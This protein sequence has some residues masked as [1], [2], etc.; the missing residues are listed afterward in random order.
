MTHYL[1]MARFRSSIH[2][3]NRVKHVVDKSAS[4]TG[5]TTIGESLI[6]TVDAPVLAL[7]EQVVTGSKVHGIYL[8]V[9]VASNEVQNLGAIPN[10]YM[11]VY[12]NVANA[13]GTITPNAV[14]PSDKKRYVIHQEMVMIE[15]TGRGGN[16]RILFNGVIKIPKG[17]SRFG[18]SDR[19]TM[20]LLSP[21]L[22]IVYCFQVHYKEFR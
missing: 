19:L 13:V 11:A 21:V 3:V 12:K 16:A 14:G 2:P 10:V 6:T 1:Q 15:N 22:D 7:P 5:G 20:T 9:E 17:Y 4:L 18:P 8:K